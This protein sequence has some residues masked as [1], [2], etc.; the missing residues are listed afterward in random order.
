MTAAQHE[1]QIWEAQCGL[2][3]DALS[4]EDA[5]H[6]P[7]V[8]T[9]M[10][11]A[12]SLL[13]ITGHHKSGSPPTSLPSRTRDPVLRRRTPQVSGWQRNGVAISV[14][15]AHSP[16]SN[17]RKTEGDA[18]LDRG[19]SHHCHRTK[20]RYTAARTSSQ[21]SGDKLSKR[22]ARSSIGGVRWGAKIKE[23][24]RSSAKP[25]EPPK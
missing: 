9:R 7:S 20:K 25:S 21:L 17:H 1:R 4:F 5:I 24:G 11:A 23:A 6:D 16:P 10:V 18:P 19:G 13:I 15:D 3:D 12:E 2:P 14:L 8:L 22:C